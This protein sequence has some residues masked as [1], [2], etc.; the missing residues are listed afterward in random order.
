MIT[1]KLNTGCSVVV[2]PVVNEVILKLP[3]ATLV[4]KIS[5]KSVPDFWL[6]MITSVAATVELVTVKVAGVALPAA[7]IRVIAPETLLRVTPVV[8]LVPWVT[9]PPAPVA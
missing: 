3:A 2:P 7:E 6:T 8:L 5:Y 1:A 4:T 9:A